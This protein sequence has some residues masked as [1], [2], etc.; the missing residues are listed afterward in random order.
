MDLS[1]LVLAGS[2]RLSLNIYLIHL[3]ILPLNSLALP[4][5]FTEEPIISSTNQNINWPSS[6]T[7]TYTTNNGFPLHIQQSESQPQLPEHTLL[8]YQF[9]TCREFLQLFGRVFAQVDIRLNVKPRCMLSSVFLKPTDRIVE[10]ECH[11][12]DAVYEYI[13]ETGRS[14]KD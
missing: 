10:S 1:L 11:D 3:T 7:S 2:P 5:P 4:K 12:C 14:L 13:G 8:S 9:H 6:I